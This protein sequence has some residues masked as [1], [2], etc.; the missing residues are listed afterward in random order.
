MDGISE[1]LRK[2]VE[3][4]SIDKLASFVTHLC[5]STHSLSVN[6]LELLAP[7]LSNDKNDNLAQNVY[8]S[9]MNDIFLK[10]EKKDISKEERNVLVKKG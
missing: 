7:S 5:K 6:V 1:S 10:L 2:T 9:I 3:Q 4:S 8:T